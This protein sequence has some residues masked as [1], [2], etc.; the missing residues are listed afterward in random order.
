MADMPFSGVR[1][2]DPRI[3]AVVL[4]VSVV[5]G[6]GYFLDRWINDSGRPDL[7]AHAD[8]KRAEEID[9]RFKQGVIML[10]AK[11]Y[12]HAMTAFYRVLQLAPKMPEA[13]VNMGFAMLGQKRYQEALV[14]FDSAT[15]LNR[16]QLNAYFGMA[17]AQEGLGNYRGALEAMEAWLHRAKPDDPFRRRA[18]AAVW[19]WREKLAKDA[20]PAAK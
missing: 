15:E 3:I 8:R 16:N 18:E 9:I 1:R 19:E 13:H 12:D 10:H 20:R 14:F 5:A 11:Q 2:A 7:K 17:E 6:G 4:M